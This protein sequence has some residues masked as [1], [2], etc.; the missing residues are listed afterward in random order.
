MAPN[1]ALNEWQ[2]CRTT[3][4]RFD[5]SLAD[6][7]KYGF[8]L[9]TVL[10]TANALIVDKNIAVDRPAASIVVM[11][12]LFALFMLDNYY[13]D[14]VRGAVGR[15]KEL[16]EKGLN[17]QAFQLT[18]AISTRVRITHA[19]G[20]ILGVYALFVVVAWGIGITAWFA[21]KPDAPSGLY[22]LFVVAAVE[23]VAMGAVFVIVQPDA[24][25][26]KIFYATGVG[27]AFVRWRARR[28]ALA[29]KKRDGGDSPPAG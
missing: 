3:I 25:P 21:A 6:T 11:V 23:L 15:A 9:V 16:E 8:T 4:G 12:L 7:R 1:Q 29:D 27:Q 26:S 5:D 10:L 22:L 18:G 14:L 19:T 2:E 17:G 24:P 20:L 13:W 28:K